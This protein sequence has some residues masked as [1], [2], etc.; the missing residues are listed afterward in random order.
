MKTLGLF[1]SFDHLENL[2]PKCSIFEV[3]GLLVNAAACRS[4]SHFARLMPVDAAFAF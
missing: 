1:R 3:A 2:T 4:H